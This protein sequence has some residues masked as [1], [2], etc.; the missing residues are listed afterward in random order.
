MNVFWRHRFIKLLL[1]VINMSIITENKIKQIHT[2][3][4]MEVF[5]NY[6]LY[7]RNTAL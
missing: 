3:L 1:N 7:N 4:E 6:F 5:S 2:F